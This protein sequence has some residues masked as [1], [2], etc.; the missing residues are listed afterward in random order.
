MKRRGD[1]LLLAFCAALLALAVGA[2][3]L[4]AQIAAG[5]VNLRTLAKSTTAAGNVTSE[6]T[7]ATIQGMHTAIASWM[8]A[9][10]PTVGQ[11]T[12]AASLPVA[13]ASDQSALP[14]A[15]PNGLATLVTGQQAVTASAAALP[16]QAAKRVCIK[17]L[18]AGT[19][20]VYY[21]VTG[22]TTGTGMELSPGD[23]S[24]V[25]ADNVSRIFV[26]GAGTGS[27]VAWEAWN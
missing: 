19:Q 1:I 11:K 8:G 6:N 14:T 12:M 25:P 18:A 20:V 2:H 3:D 15:L 26:I 5:T 22:V 10:T 16:S 27:T 7:S 23:A 21:G 4:G 13:F 24:C 9:T 17:V